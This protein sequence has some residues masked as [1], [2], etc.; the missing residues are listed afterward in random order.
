[1]KLL[2]IYIR[3]GDKYEGEPLYKYII[4]VLKE[5]NISGATVVKGIYGYGER[6][7]SDFNILSL[8]VDLPIIVEAVDEDEKIKKVFKK[9][10]EILGKNGLAIIISCEK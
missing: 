7:I 6:G 5:N 8:S 3:E 1:M 10:K 9:I 4:R 2:K